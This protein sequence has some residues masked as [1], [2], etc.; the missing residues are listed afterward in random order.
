LRTRLHRELFD[1]PQ[2]EGQRCAVIF[3]EPAN[4]VITDPS[5]LR[6]G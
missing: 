6:R 3:L 4:E 5:Q 2:L 1:L